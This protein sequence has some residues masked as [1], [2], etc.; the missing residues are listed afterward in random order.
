MSLVVVGS[1]NVPGGAVEGWGAGRRFLSKGGS[2]Y[3]RLILGV[4]IHDL[5]TGYK[6]FHRRV[7]EAIQLET[8]H[9]NGYS[10]QIEMTYRALRRG[11]RVVEVPIAFRDR[12]IGRSKMCVTSRASRSSIGILLPFGHPRSIEEVGAA[13]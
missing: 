6:A 10:F 4:P 13:T 12:T 9:S 11:F 5:T 3:S 8:V 2:A 1:R 7:L